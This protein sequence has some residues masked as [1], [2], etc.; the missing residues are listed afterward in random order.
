MIKLLGSFKLS[1]IIKIVT[2]IIIVA[3]ISTVSILSIK[4]KSLKV[5]LKDITSAN[6]L[7]T[8]EVETKNINL[9]E[10]EKLVISNEESYLLQIKSR[11]QANNLFCANE[12]PPNKD[13]SSS[14]AITSNMLQGEASP[15]TKA[16]RNV[17]DNQSYIAIGFIN[18]Y[19][20]SLLLQTDNTSTD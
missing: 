1:T 9:L 19:L 13:V 17:T 2:T 20:G 10:L 16:G 5:E 7:L 11:E 12:T 8:F 18:S 14:A 15:T 3:L 4:N 6:D